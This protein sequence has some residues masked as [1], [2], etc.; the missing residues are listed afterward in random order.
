MSNDKVFDD[1]IQEVTSVSQI[2]ISGSAS[3]SIRGSGRLKTTCQQVKS[4]PHKASPFSK[5]FDLGSHR[6]AHNPIFNRAT[7]ILMLIVGNS[8]FGGRCYMSVR[9]IS[10]ELSCDEAN[11]RKIIKQLEEEDF[12]LK[13]DADPTSYWITNPYCFFVGD[14]ESEEV[15]KRVWSSKKTKRLSEQRKRKQIA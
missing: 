9:M 15:A 12:I 13:V 7:R 5:L 3:Q 14:S 2:E 6:V 10:D 1:F 8:T 4:N 11:V